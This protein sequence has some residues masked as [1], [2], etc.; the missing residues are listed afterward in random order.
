[1]SAGPM[2][3]AGAGRVGGGGEAALTDPAFPG[4]AE[5][6]GSC[7]EVTVLRHRRG[8]RLTLRVRRADGRAEIVK[9][10]VSGVALAHDNQ[11][12]LA[13]AADALDFSVSRPLW[14]GAGGRLLAQSICPGRP[15][16]IAT[17]A[18][19]SGAR[20]AAAMGRA[21][22]SLHRSGIRFDD[23]FTPGDQHARSLRHLARLRRVSPAL[24]A[25]A[26]ELCGRTEAL[27]RAIEAESAP[28]LMPLHGSLHL[29]QWLVGSNGLALVDFDRASMGDPELDSATFVADLE[30][31]PEAVARPLI[32]AF[33]EGVG[34][35]D[36]RRFDYYRVHKHLAKVCRTARA[37][38]G[39]A[40]DKAARRLRRA[41]TLLERAGEGVA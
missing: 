20:V 5:V 12:R 15:F 31:E 28:A 24:A 14:R 19:A 36:R 10:V 25:E 32:R 27:R 37:G 16:D 30:H 4:L 3:R 2:E 21:V 11:C 13:E 23:T 29:Q 17:G 26:A 39:D 35:I 38:S 22:A 7:R 34:D 33:L 9:Y 40:L 6:L 18:D 41:W 1:M 8:K